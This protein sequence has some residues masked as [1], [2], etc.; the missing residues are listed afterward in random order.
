MIGVKLIDTP[1]MQKTRINK[2]RF[3]LSLYDMFADSFSHFLFQETLLFN[4]SWKNILVL[5]AVWS[6][7]LVL[8]ILKV[9]ILPWTYL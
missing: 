4:L 5:M 6:S 1:N 3:A 8:Q 9:H 2:T 7:F